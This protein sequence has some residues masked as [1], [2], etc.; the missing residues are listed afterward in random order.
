MV[1]TDNGAGAV[2]HWYCHGGRGELLTRRT[3]ADCASSPVDETYTYDAAGNITT[4]SGGGLQTTYTYV[5]QPS[6]L[7]PILA[8]TQA[9]T[10]TTDSAGLTTRITGGASP[11]AYA[12]DPEGRLVSVCR[13]TACTG[14]GFDRV[15]YAYDGAGHRTQVR[16]T[17]AGGTVTTLE[18]AFTGDA[19]AQDRVNGTV[20]RTYVTDETGRISRFCD[21]ECT[22]AN[23]VYLVAWNAHG[24]AL[25]VGRLDPATGGVTVANRYAYL[26][27]GTPTTT[28]VNGY[29]DLGFR[30]L[31]VGA[32]D[33]QW[34]NSIGQNLLYMHARTYS[35]VLGRFLTPDPARADGNLYAYAGNSPV[36]KTDPSGLRPG[37]W[38][39]LH[40]HKVRPLSMHLTG[41]A[42]SAGSSAFCRNLMARVQNA[43]KW[44]A[45]AAAVACFFAGLLAGGTS[46]YVLIR[47]GYN[48]R[49]GE[50][51]VSQTL[52]TFEDKI[53]YDRGWT[54]R[55]YVEYG[56]R[57][58]AQALAG[59]RGHNNYAI[60][61]C[62]PMKVL[63]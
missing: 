18:T 40:P 37:D 42:V 16:T 46:D 3:G 60:M 55:M 14:S 43:P 44:F 58:C 11:W 56:G 50:V 2:T 28:P 33:V 8:T 57:M 12:Y 62:G 41:V 5:V 59:I 17:T 36:T 31:Y 29:P 13:S 24:D 45:P 7:T 19:P 38:V 63:P 47:A 21:P 27:W 53:G 39:W 49:T 30:Y 25:T 9:L 48:W 26:T 61:S 6:I 10:V 34:D 54:R 4:A 52:Y 35:P 1:T 23:P 20:T 22:G 51:L 15:D 32:A